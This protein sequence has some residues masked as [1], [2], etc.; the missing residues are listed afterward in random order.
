MS[1]QQPRDNG[2]QVLH[3]FLY[4]AVENAMFTF[5]CFKWQTGISWTKH[6]YQRTVFKLRLRIQ[7]EKWKLSNKSKAAAKSGINTEFLASLVFYQWGNLEL[8]RRTN[9]FFSA[10]KINFIW[11]LFVTYYHI[12]V[13]LGFRFIWLSKNRLCMI[14]KL[15]SKFDTTKYK[16]LLMVCRILPST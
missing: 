12:W 13:F 15:T 3:D 14:A 9:C 1:L 6:P 4:H 5:K 10:N 2:M 11:L 16:F 7:I 8:S